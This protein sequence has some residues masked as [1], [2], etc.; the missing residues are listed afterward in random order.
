MSITYNRPPALEV[1]LPS[2]YECISR[3]SPERMVISSISRVDI[4]AFLSPPLL[5]I[6]PLNM[7]P[8]HKETMKGEIYREDLDL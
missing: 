2:P 3:S 4:P 8:Q 1:E 5:I 7:C 6:A